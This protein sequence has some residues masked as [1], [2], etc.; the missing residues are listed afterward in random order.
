MAAALSEEQILRYSRQILLKEVGGAG[1]RRLLDAKVLVCDAGPV[2]ATAAD[3]LEASGCQT[4]GDS[5]QRG[6]SPD[7]E[8]PTIALGPASTAWH[9]TGPWLAWGGAGDEARLVVRAPDACAD[10]FRESVG[11]LSNVAEPFALFVGST[12]ALVAQRVLL[13][14]LQDV[15]AYR[16]RPPAL[17]DPAPITRCA[18]HAD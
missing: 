7:P 12:A 4:L 14:A 15:R 13:G 10:C 9:G 16:L 8:A 18:S 11:G 17:I 5:P 1:Q 2:G 3:F 6:L